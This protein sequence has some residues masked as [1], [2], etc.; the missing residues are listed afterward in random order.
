MTLLASPHGHA[1]HIAEY[2]HATKMN[3]READ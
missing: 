3:P 1:V 2:C